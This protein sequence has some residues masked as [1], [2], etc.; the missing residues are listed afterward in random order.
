MDN[1]LY[2]EEKKALHWQ[3]LLERLIVYLKKNNPEVWD[4]FTKELSGWL[5]ENNG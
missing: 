5:N 3:Y 2:P 4:Q 1:I